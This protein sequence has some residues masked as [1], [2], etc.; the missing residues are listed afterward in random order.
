M[1]T[2]Y[3]CCGIA[4]F[5]FM[6]QESAHA[7]E[8][9][10]KITNESGA[11]LIGQSV[12]AGFSN[13]TELTAIGQENS[14]CPNTF[15]NASCTPLA[16]N[17]VV[18]MIADQTITDFRKAF[19]LRLKWMKVELMVVNPAANNTN[20]VAEK[21]TLTDLYITKMTQTVASDGTV[22]F[23]ISF[24]PTTIAWTHIAISNSGIPQSPRTFTWNRQTNTG[25]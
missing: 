7:Q 22:S 1:K 8:L 18:N 15:T 25:N 21:I 14:A 11:V 5:L 4:A 12:M 24:D 13:L 16:D 6:L 10:M 19:F 3:K 23:Q 2:F 20:Y 17:F 9:F